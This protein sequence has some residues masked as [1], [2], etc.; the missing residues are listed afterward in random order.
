[1]R[2]VFL[3]TS[4]GVIKHLVGLAQKRGGILDAAIRHGG[5]PVADGYRNG[6]PLHVQGIGIEIVPEAM[7]EILHLPSRNPR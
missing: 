4:L 6:Y 7:D 1:L 3:L 2:G 5:D